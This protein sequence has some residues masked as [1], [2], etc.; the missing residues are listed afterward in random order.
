M[1]YFAKFTR[2][3]GTPR[4]SP[5]KGTSQLGRFEKAWKTAQS[6]C[7]YQSKWRGMSVDKTPLPEQLTAMFDLLVQE[8]IQQ[9][10]SD[11][12]TTGACME[13][14][15]GNGVLE[16]LVKLAETDQPVGARGTVISNLS[17]FINL[18]DD[19][20]LAQKAVHNPIL[21]LLHWFGS[22]D[23]SEEEGPSY[24]DI[25]VDLLYALCSKIRGD[26]VL[27]N[28]FFQDRKWL[29]SVEQRSFSSDSIAAM[30]RSIES[31]R[32]EGGSAT[33]GYVFL[34]FSHL[35]RYVHRDGEVGDTART[36]LLFLLELATTEIMASSG[37]STALEQ[38]ILDDSGF[39][40]IL[41]ATLG[42]MYSQ[43]PRSLQITNGP[44]AVIPESFPSYSADLQN[45][46][47]SSIFSANDFGVA[48]RWADGRAPIS[49]SSPE[50]RACLSTFASLLKFIQEVL[51]RCP[52]A[53]VCT[54]LL[55]NL[56]DNFLQ[57]ILYPSLLESSDTDGSSV[58]VMRYLE[59]M[60]H[61]ARHE[62]LVSTV[63]GFLTDEDPE[64]SLESSPSPANQSS[65]ALADLPQVSSP[66]P[67]TLR[68]LVYT[69]MQS[70]VSVDAVVSALNLLRLILTKHC[71]YSSRLIEMEPVQPSGLANGWMT[72]CTVAIDVHRQELEMY[73][74]LMAQLQ[75]NADKREVDSPRAL[76]IP[77]RHGAGMQLS[78][79]PR[80]E[81]RMLM[82]ESFTIGYDEYLE[83]AA[84]DWDAHQTYHVELD[85]LFAAQAA[86]DAAE[87]PSL[88]Q[89][90]TQ[91]A[92]AIS[93]RKQRR[94][95]PRKYSEAVMSP[96]AAAKNEHMAPV[97]GE[98]KP[99]TAHPCQSKHVKYHIKQSDPIIRAIMTLLT[100][101]FA[102][103]RECNL[104]LTGV[105]SALVGCSFRTIDLW[106][107]FSIPAL[108]TGVLSKPW[109]VWMENLRNL[110]GDSSEQSS[111][112]SDSEGD[113]EPSGRSN[114]KYSVGGAPAS[115]IAAANAKKYIGLDR[116]LQEA[117]HQLPNGAT[118]PS[119]YLVLSGLVQQATVLR[120]EIPDFT[121]R[122]KRA[123]N[124]LMG[125]VEDAD[126]LDE[127]LESSSDTRSRNRDRGLS[128]A[129]LENAR[130]ISGI[131]QPP[132]DIGQ[133]SPRSRSTSVSTA[134]R[135][136]RPQDIQPLTDITTEP[137]RR[138]SNSGN[139]ASEAASIASSAITNTKS[140]AHSTSTA[141][142]LESPSQ[143]ALNIPPANANL[144]EFLENVIILQESI[145]EI[146]ARVQVRRENG[147]D[148][149]AVM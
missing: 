131:S 127:E 52:S 44:A 141:G 47:E 9:A 89:S 123:R 86:R 63:M 1:E 69:N 25:F 139:R 126:E 70:S 92:S 64:S 90:A 115:A 62:D 83:D 66:L 77:W 103:P 80:I 116:E 43:L 67:F 41:S 49:S 6:I 59:T 148:E 42:A 109:L 112:S 100:K 17:T 132:S 27:L 60:L 4:R 10:D 129:S 145:K 93:P 118:P 24:D 29:K 104:A 105:L 111:E 82:P 149:N 58:A 72:N 125:V 144:A 13:Y 108:L 30:M 107:G 142:A 55:N 35:L 46:I 57:T 45:A 81:A 91:P 128:S 48:D 88:P 40:A 76:H 79:R 106:L 98:P 138:R 96:P 32:S 51:Y 16:A 15:L 39:A 97:D 2:H 94:M 85:A 110:S 78:E 19:K 113:T 87:Q 3:I 5:S 28:I 119:L 136:Q 20:L 23:T 61:I 26:P 34:L 75:G 143:N 68:D 71:R 102:Q 65:A 38:F 84:H 18:A 99:N 73:A 137:S 12:W 11:D 56:R 37:G 53:Q 50:F 133:L 21:E 117:V 7:Y 54:Q 31:L 121:R 147:G 124:A 120:N 134:R 114:R 22:T 122:L 33:S 14:L 140:T 95:R 130:S 36:S 101:Y 74:R 8:D 146:I 135:S